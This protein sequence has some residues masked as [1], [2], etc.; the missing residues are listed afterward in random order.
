MVGGSRVA[1]VRRQIIEF[2]ES[3]IGR[4]DVFG[5]IA[6]GTPLVRYC[7]L[8]GADAQEFCERFDSATA[9]ATL[10]T[11]RSRHTSVG[12]LFALIAVVLIVALIH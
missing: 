6:D 8:H 9:T 5:A 2:L 10:K 12:L 3:R 1:Q 11:A 7:F 4:F